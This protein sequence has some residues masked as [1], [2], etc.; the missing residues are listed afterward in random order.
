[1]GTHA[2]QSLV[3]TSRLSVAS[4]R[5]TLPFWNHHAAGTSPS[6]PQHP[7][8]GTSHDRPTCYVQRQAIACRGRIRSSKTCKAVAI[9]SWERH[10]KRREWAEQY[11]VQ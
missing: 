3:L 5:T 6:E 11:P 8:P 2:P 10:R 7:D 4:E 9:K 1:M